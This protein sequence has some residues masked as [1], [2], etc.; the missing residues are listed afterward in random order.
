VTCRLAIAAL[1]LWLAGMAWAA[2][3][4]PTAHDAATARAALRAALQLRDVPLS[5][6]ASCRQ[7]G[8]DAADR[9][10]GDYFAGQLAAMDKPSN[11]I[12]ARCDAGPGTRRTCSVWWRHRDEEERWA[13]GLAFELDAKGR[14]LT[15]SVR[16]LGAG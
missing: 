12:S 3:E 5:V 11:T 2:E 10:V 13:W 6:H 14:A 7:A 4:Q 16:C 8:A 9:T 1:G 15:R